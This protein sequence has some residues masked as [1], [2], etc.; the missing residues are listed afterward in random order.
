MT[1]KKIIQIDEDI[2]VGCG[3]CVAECE[4]GALEVIDGRARLVNENFCDGLGNCI[5]DCPT[6]ALEIIESPCKTKSHS[7]PGSKVV[8]K[9]PKEDNTDSN[10]NQWPIQLQLVPPTAPYFEEADLLVTADC[11]AVAYNKY[12][13]L[14]SDKAVAMGCPKL[15]DGQ[16]YIDK[17]T[18]IIES[19]N[20][21]SITV[22]QMEVPCC[23]KMT[24]IV[25][26]AIKQAGSELE[27]EIL[28]IKVN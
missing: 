19:N 28:T 26:E 1:T 9:N 27:P 21:N 24:W 3:N 2:C 10:L 6:G 8:N 4:E 17:L 25:K 5:G 23:Q 7:C 12:Q 20:L 15:D 14:L 11:V 22:A 13:D 16:A 18:A